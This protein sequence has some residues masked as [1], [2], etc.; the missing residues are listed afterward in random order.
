MS[1]PLSTRHKEI[2][3][4]ALDHFRRE[5]PGTTGFR[6]HQGI[7]FD[8]LQEATTAGIEMLFSSNKIVLENK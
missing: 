3:I 8:E 6:Q 2:I 4:K 5:A 1:K 7:T